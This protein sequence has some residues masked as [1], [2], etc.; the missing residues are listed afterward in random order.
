MLLPQ[1]AQNQTLWTCQTFVCV[2]SQYP[3]RKGEQRESCLLPFVARGWHAARSPFNCLLAAHVFSEGQTL[4]A[5]RSV[6]CHSDVIGLQSI[7]QAETFPQMCIWTVGLAIK[8]SANCRF[9]FRTSNKY[10]A[11]FEEERKCQ[12][13]DSYLPTFGLMGWGIA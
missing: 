5:L 2:L 12:C 6:A 1:R 9:D 4:P 11:L 10:E 3:K 13:F 7:Q 8:T